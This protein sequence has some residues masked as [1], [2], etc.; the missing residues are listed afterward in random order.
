[1]DYIRQN[2]LLPPGM[3]IVPYYDRGDLVG[4]TTH[5]VIE[6]VVVGMIL[7]TIILVL[8]L[9]HV[10]AALITALNV[11]LALLAAFCGMVS[12]GTPST[13]ISIGAVDFGIVADSTVIV[14]ESIFHFL[15]SHG[16]GRI[17]GRIQ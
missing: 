16:R 12:T 6:N 5:T 2:H 14:M 17:Q 10:R 8:F 13:L 15:G 9:G 7:V 11:P 4:L 1:V 3:E